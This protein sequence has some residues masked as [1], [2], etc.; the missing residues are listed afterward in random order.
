M[1]EEQNRLLM[2]SFTVFEIALMVIIGVI[3]VGYLV[4]AIE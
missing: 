2:R 1:H 3:L 4:Q